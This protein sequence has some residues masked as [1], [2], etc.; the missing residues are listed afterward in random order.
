MKRRPIKEPLK[1]VPP[2]EPKDFAH[3]PADGWDACTLAVRARVYV[4][5][6]DLGSPNGELPD[7]LVR[8]WAARHPDELAPEG[9]T[10]A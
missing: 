5:A 4:V 10:A 2:F 1:D 9:I 6:H 7:R 8:E 3:A